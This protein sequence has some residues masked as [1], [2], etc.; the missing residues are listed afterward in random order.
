MVTIKNITANEVLDSR[1]NP[2]L[3]AHVILSDET[4]AQAIVPSGASTG[5]KEALELRDN[6]QNR[7][8]G[9]GVLKACS[10]VNTIIH[11]HLK[12]LSPFE[13]SNIDNL[14]IELDGTDNFSHLG[15]NASLA[16]SMALA[17]AAAKSLNIPLYRYIGGIN[18]LTLPIPLLNIINGGSHADNS[19]DFQEYMIA[20]IGFESFAEALRASTEVYHSLKNILKSLNHITSIGDEGGFAPNLSN[21]TEP[22]EL[23]LQAIEKAHYKAGTEIAIALDIASSEFFKNGKYHLKGENRSLES[24]EMITYYE[25]IVAQYPIISIEDGLSED[26]WNGWIS[27]TQKLGD[28]VQLVGDDLFVTN[29]N[30]LQNGINEQIANAILIKPN[31]I[32]TISQTIQAV[33]LA[34]RNNYRCIMSHRSGESEDTFIADFAVALNTGEIKTGSTARSERI[35]KYNR[36]LTIEREL[37]HGTYLGKSLFKGTNAQR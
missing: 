25:K 37:K 27:L 14:L 19:I 33:H 31:Q 6:D 2:T 36:L 20:P 7:Y 8:G 21:N 13:Q 16:V 23:I 12:G 17:Q 28:K 11:N 4:H 32:G 18:A 24:A 30:I 35:A 1:G 29:A 15:A 26:D 5:K 3:Q 10:S 22:I 34:Q 9:K